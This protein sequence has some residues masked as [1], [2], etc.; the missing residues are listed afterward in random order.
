[1]ARKA[2]RSFTSTAGGLRSA[3]Y[4]FIVTNVSQLCCTVGCQRLSC[5]Q[6]VKQV[7][8]LLSYPN[9]HLG[10]PFLQGNF[11]P[12]LN[13][14]FTVN[15]PLLTAAGTAAPA[16]T[17]LPAKAVPGSKAAA[18]VHL[19]A[20][21]DGS[22]NGVLFADVTADDVKQQRD[23]SSSDDSSSS[24]SKLCGSLDRLPAGLDGVFLRVGPNP[25]LKPL[26]G[27]HWC[28]TWLLYCY[29]ML[30]CFFVICS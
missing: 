13:E 14:I 21:A 18:A 25:L 28:V 8:W 10:Q 29:F 1:V 22:A 15:L 30:L 16:A 4:E 24:S 9:R 2:L 7:Q 3:L 5:R 27:Y 20:T 12:Q 26:G 6:V 19:T 17:A 11:A 23:T